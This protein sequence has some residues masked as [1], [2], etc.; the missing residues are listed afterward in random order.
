MELIEHVYA[1]PSTQS[2]CQTLSHTYLGDCHSHSHPHPPY[3]PAP[4]PRLRL[5]EP[6]SDVADA[7]PPDQRPQRV[8]ATPASPAYAE[9]EELCDADADD[10][11]VR[12]FQFRFRKRPSVSSSAHYEDVNPLP[13]TATAAA[14][15]VAATTGSGVT[16]LILTQLRGSLIQVIGYKCDALPSYY[17]NS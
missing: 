15:A 14:A 11:T 13:A 3:P 4:A 2:T 9:V 5:M 17:S 8:P 1:V 7:R 16:S 12:R 6:Y 10:R